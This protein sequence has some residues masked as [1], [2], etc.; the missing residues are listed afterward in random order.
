MAEK[1]EV[2]QLFNAP[3]SRLHSSYRLVTVVVCTRDRTNDLAMCLEALLQLDYPYLDFLVV[4]NAPTTNATQ[5]LVAEK[6]P[7]V[8]YVCEPRPGLD[9]ARNR[10]I[11]EAKGEIIAYTDDDVIVDAGWVKAL[12]QPF[13]EDASVMA[14]TGLVAPYELE[15][16]AQIMFEMYGGLVEVSNDAGA[17]L[18]KRVTN[19]NTEE[20]VNL[21]PERIWL[22]VAGPLT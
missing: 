12:V 16:S 2:E 20:P 10:A 13:L 9:W 18:T 4:D 19:G 3:V 6:F 11:V 8:R 5:Q 1:L 15:T 21:E 14:V 22:T 7:Q 17:V